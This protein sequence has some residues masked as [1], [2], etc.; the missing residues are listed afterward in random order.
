M[1]DIEIQNSIYPGLLR[2]NYTNPGTGFHME[3]VRFTGDLRPSAWICENVETRFVNVD[4]R[5]MCIR[6]EE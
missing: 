4:P 5:G 6:T 2:L 3:N 1:R